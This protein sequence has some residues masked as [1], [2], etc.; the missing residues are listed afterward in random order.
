MAI[1][2]PIVRAAFALGMLAYYLLVQCVFWRVITRIWSKGSISR[3]R[4]KLL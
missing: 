4:T 3:K 1:A 2:S